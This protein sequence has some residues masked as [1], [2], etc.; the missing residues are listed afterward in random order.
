MEHFLK[1]WESQ[2]LV[3][4]LWS[5]ACFALGVSFCASCYWYRIRSAMRRAARTLDEI[6]AVDKLGPRHPS[7]RNT[8]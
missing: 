5:F 2:A 3:M 4:L 6:N 8:D 7:R 1:L